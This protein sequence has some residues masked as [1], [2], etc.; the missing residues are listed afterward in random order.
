MKL[1]RYQG[2]L[3]R[4]TDI[5]GRVATGVADTDPP[6]YGL[7]EFHRDEESVRIGE[8]RIFESD[9]DHIELLPTYEEAAAAIPP[10][11]YRHFK[12]REYEVITVARH[13][14]TEEPMVV[15]RALYGDFGVWVRPAD[16]W[17][18][19]VTRDGRTMPRFV[20]LEE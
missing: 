16:M 8:S 14:E 19:Q 5:R 10:G 1:F 18:G 11:R 17:C 20:R 4:V 3:V 6:D 12:G 15:Y 9:I 2:R 13:S 7:Q